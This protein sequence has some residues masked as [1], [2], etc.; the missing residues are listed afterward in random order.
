M[1]IGSA[2]FRPPVFNKQNHIFVWKGTRNWWKWHPYFRGF[3]VGHFPASI[4]VG[5]IL[6][7]LCLWASPTVIADGNGYPVTYYSPMYLISGVLFIGVP[8]LF[9]M[10][11]IIF[12]ETEISVKNSVLRI[13]NKNYDIQNSELNFKA[14]GNGKSHEMPF[15]GNYPGSVSLI[16]L[17]GGNEIV[18]I[19]IGID[20]YRSAHLEQIESAARQIAEA[21]E[22]DFSL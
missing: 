2:V 1:K 8:S 19:Y 3:R 13:E 4:F 11:K 21:A 17:K 22:I 12:S 10:H 9:Y 15:A 6:G 5:L 16:F 7:M 20:P 18:R 14:F